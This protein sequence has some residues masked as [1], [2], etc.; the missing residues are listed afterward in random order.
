MDR[1]SVTLIPSRALLR[2]KAI[3]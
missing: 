3:L 1:E 2:W